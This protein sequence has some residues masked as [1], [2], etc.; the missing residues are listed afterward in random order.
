M[1]ITEAIMLIAAGLFSLLLAD[2]TQADKPQ[3][4][5]V[6]F[7]KLLHIFYIIGTTE[8]YIQVLP[9]KRDSQT[10]P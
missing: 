9:H 10:A 6:R 5:N 2:I 4:N 1:K 7:S 8:K 3:N